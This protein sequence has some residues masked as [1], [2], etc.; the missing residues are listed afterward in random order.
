MTASRWRSEI[1]SRGITVNVRRA[2]LHRDRHDA[3]LPEEQQK[4]LLGQIAAGP[5][6]EPADIARGGLPGRP[7]AA[8]ITGEN[9][10]S[11]AACT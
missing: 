1:G 5:L 4:A 11:T 2:G 9:C 10:T 7:P 6:G 3:A 8:Y